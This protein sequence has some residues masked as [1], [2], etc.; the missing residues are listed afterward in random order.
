M[1]R[2]EGSTNDPANRPANRLA[3]EASLYLRQHAHN[4]VDWYPWGPEAWEKARTEDRPIFL[5]VGYSA[6]HWCHVMERESFENESIA[7]FLNEHFVSIKVDREERPDVDEIY[8]A[9]VQMISQQGGWPMSVFLTPDLRPFFGGTYFPPQDVQGR[10]GFLRLL[11]GIVDAYTNRRAEIDQGAG[12]VA[13][14]LATMTGLPAAEGERSLRPWEDAVT[15]LHENFDEVNG[16]FGGAPK[17]PPSFSIQVLLR[18]NVRRPNERVL[19]IVHRT[20]EGMAEG[21][22]Y[23]Q[24]GGGFHRYSVDEKWLAPHFEKMLY[25]QGLLLLAY[26]EAYQATQRPLYAQVLRETGEYLLR[27]MTSPEGA[28]Y[29]AE[30]A[31]SEGEEGRFYV[32]DLQ[33]VR[34]LL[35]AEAADLF[36]HAYDVDEVGN[37]EGKTILRR[38]ASTADLARRFSL[39]EPDVEKALDASRKIL[40]KERES[41]VRPARDEKVLVAWNGLAIRGL[42]RA[43][44]VLNE[45]R[46]VEAAARAAQFIANS[47]IVDGRLQRVF[48]DGKAAFPAYLEDAASYL[49]ALVELYEV[50]FE[51]KWLDLATEQADAMSNHFADPAGGFF[52]TADDHDGLVVRVKV[53]QDG[54]T[55]SGNSSAAEALLRLGRLTGREDFLQAARGAMASYQ[56]YLE[57]VPAGLQQM[58]IALDLDWDPPLDVVLAGAPEAEGFDELRG[59]L[60]SSFLPQAVFAQTNDGAGDEPNWLQGKR[61]VDGKAALYVCR[62][63]ACQAPTT[64]PEE[65][66]AQLQ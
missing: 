42:A 45:P 4:P 10:P 22:L 13:E 54:S 63:H 8:M 56:S 30:D 38:V 52:H 61:P 2:T 1:D 44:Y 47:M 19:E 14:G 53:G 25:D 24:L 51:K 16:G 7:A 23:D 37:W 34:D 6:C 40:F 18:E 57:K 11:N 62:D 49:A 27:D 33:Q 32:W 12:Q 28:F 65:A 29:S 58:L 43:G 17:F 41:R 9:A 20:L 3:K 21:G 64:E 26:A 39:S 5:S 55:P 15:Q 50:T 66:R 36:T 46:F 31:D 48:A 59:V 35:P 60:R